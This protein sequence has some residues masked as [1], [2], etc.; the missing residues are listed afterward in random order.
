MDAKIHAEEREP[1]S[2]P[3]AEECDLLTIPEG[4]AATEQTEIIPTAERIPWIGDLRNPGI[5][6]MVVLDD[7]GFLVP[8]CTAGD[9]LRGFRSLWRT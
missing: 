2:D 7:R 3:L 4:A 8:L 9:L 5:G 1:V 6:P